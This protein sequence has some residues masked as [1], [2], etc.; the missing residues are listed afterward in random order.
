MF[1]D[2]AANSRSSVRLA[3]FLI[4]AH[5]IPQVYQAKG[6]EIAVI[7]TETRALNDK[8]NRAYWASGGKDYPTPIGATVRIIPSD[9]SARPLSIRVGERASA[10]FFD[11]GRK[12]LVVSSGNKEEEI[13]VSAFETADGHLTSKFTIPKLWKFW[14]LPTGL[15]GPHLNFR[16]LIY[17]GQ[18]KRF[19]LLAES[20]DES[21]APEQDLPIQQCSSIAFFNDRELNSVE[22][23]REIPS[24]EARFLNSSL[25]DRVVISAIHLRPEPG[26]VAQISE[27]SKSGNISIIGEIPNYLLGPYAIN[28]DGKLVFMHGT[29]GLEQIDLS[30]SALVKVGRKLIDNY[31]P[32]RPKSAKVLAL[33]PIGSGGD[34]IRCLGKELYPGLVAGSSYSLELYKGTSDLPVKTLSLGQ[35]IV[36]IKL[37]Q[38]MDRLIV[39]ADI[40]PQLRIFSIDGLEQLEVI[41]HVMDNPTDCSVW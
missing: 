22:V 35:N 28:A 38:K 12:I 10:C 21:I 30:A 11:E 19:A 26:Q 14:N 31:V 15:E 37:N 2:L 17:S 33:L 1:K 18:E 4:G 13:S 40:A 25:T 3:V 8:F 27:M 24:M 23:L 34:Y 20:T 5:L 29:G 6:Q 16:D 41:D 32:H 36:A 39:L 7:S 9:R